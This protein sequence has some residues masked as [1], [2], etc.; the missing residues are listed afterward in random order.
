MYNLK[1]LQT[2]D[3]LDFC[4]SYVC[5]GRKYEGTNLV[6]PHV[7]VLDKLDDLRIIGQKFTLL[8]WLMITFFLKKK[9]F[10]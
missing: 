10:L 9:P 5:K 8:F 2:K 3:N 6:Q 1:C 7:S 4:H